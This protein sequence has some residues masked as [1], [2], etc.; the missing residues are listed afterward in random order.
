M[1]IHKDKSAFH[2]F[3][4]MPGP[5]PSSMDAL[6]SEYLSNEGV[7]VMGVHCWTF[8]SP[9]LYCNV[10]S[11]YIRNCTLNWLSVFSFFFL[12]FERGLGFKGFKLIFSK[13]IYRR[14][15]WR[16][17]LLLSVWLTF[18]AEML[19]SQLRSWS[20]WCGAQIGLKG[21]GVTLVNEFNLL[22]HMD[23]KCQFAVIWAALWG[24]SCSICHFSPWFPT[25]SKKTR[26]S[27]ALMNAKPAPLPLFTLAIL[28]VLVTPK[29]AW[30]FL[31]NRLSCIT[32]MSRL[33]L[34]STP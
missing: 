8:N 5:V 32:S 12:F 25:T 2:T 29:S 34:L 15:V 3:V 7:K 33:W 1:K 11:T 23:R 24:S 31:R 17:R 13:R 20:P 21:S 30:I 9:T 27:A 19:I 10:W 28:E 6:L 16:Q 14:E 4:L 22:F 26:E 18:S